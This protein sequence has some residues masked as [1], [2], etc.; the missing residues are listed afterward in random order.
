MKNVGLITL[1][2]DNFGSILQ[3]YATKYTINRMGYGCKVLDLNNSILKYPFIKIDNLL[4]LIYRSIRYNGYYYEWKTMRYAMKTENKYLSAESKEEMSTFISR[5]INPKICSWRE[6]RKLG[7]DDKYFC[8]ITGSDQVWNASRKIHSIYFLKFAPPFK[9][10]AWAPS[11]GISE[12]PEFNIKHIKKGILGFSTLSVRE[13]SGKAVIKK[14][15]NSDAV[16]IPDPVLLLNADEWRQL[17]D[18][19]IVPK[20][21]YILVHFLNSPNKVAVDTINYMM[22]FL[23]YPVI[24]FAYEH[25]VYSKL[26]E[27]CF[28]NGGPE[29]YIAL[30]DKAAIVCTDSFHTTLFSIILQ[31]EFYTFYRQYL[32]NFPQNSRIVDLLTRFGL[33]ERLITDI[34]DITGL[35]PIKNMNEMLMREKN[36]AFAYLKKELNEKY[37]KRS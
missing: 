8:F 37:I 1:Y 30:I 24:C 10:I 36:T 5:K 34:G 6:L 11:F 17:E 15:V 2:K 14:L 13:E 28:T 31:K 32:H 9:R 19:S 20:E 27:Y 23:H 4:K 25:E 22:T 33:E 18:I 29:K 7:N 26:K 3:C 12:I 35:S 21:K 16:R